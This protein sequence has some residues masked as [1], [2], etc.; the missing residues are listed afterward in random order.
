MRGYLKTL[1]WI[2]KLQPKSTTIGRHKDSDLCL[3]NSGVDE[4][5]ATID[6][7]EADGCY[8][9]RDLNSAHGTYVNDCRIHNATVRLSPG[10]QLHFGYGGSTYELCID[11][12]K[13]FP[14]LAAQSPIP[15]AWGRARTPSVSPHPPTRPRPLSAGSKQGPNAPDRKTQSS[16]PGSWS[17]NTGRAC[18][19]RSK[20]P[21]NNCQSI[22]V[23]PMEEEERLHRLGDGHVRV[24]LCFEDESQRK[25]DAIM[26]LKEEVSALKLQLSQKKQGDPDVP[27]RLRCLEID[28]KEK[29]DQIQQL[30]DQ[31]LELQRCSGEMLGQAVTERD[32]RISSLL[33]QMEKLRN[34]NN[35]S[36]ALV[37]SLKKDVSAREKQAVKLATEVDKLRQDVRHKDA[38]LTSMMDK[39]EDTQKHQNE[40]LARQREAESLRKER[41]SLLTE[42]DR[43]KQLHQQTQQK[44]QRVQAEL[45]HTQSRFD[46]FR[47]RIVKT[48]QVSEKESDQKVLDHLTGLMEQMAMYKTKVH[49]CEMKFKEEAHTQRKV[50]DETQKFRARLQECQRRVQDACIADTVLMEISGLQD[51]NLSPSFSWVQEHSLSILNLLHKVLQNAAQSLQ[52]AGVDVSLKTGGVSGALQIL[53]QEHMDVQSELRKLKS[54]MQK[55]RETE[56]QSRDLHSRLEFMQKQFETEKLQAAEGQ[57]EMKNTLMRQLEEVMADLQSTR[58]AESALRREIET[59][60]AEWQAKME[61]AKVREA[62]LK[63]SLRELHLKE[64]ERSEKMKQCEEREAKALQRRAEEERQKHRV[65]VEE[66]REQVRQHAYTIV[67]M[68]TRINNAKQNEERWNKMEE[69]RDSLKEQLR[70]ALCRLEGFESSSSSTSYTSEK[71]QEPDQT[72]T[73]LRESLALSQ[74]E[75]VSQSEIINALSH[76]LAQAHARFSDMTGELNEQQK[77]ELESHKALVVDQKI[78]LSMLTQKLTMMSQLVEQKDEEIKKLGEKLR[79]TEEDLK[80]KATANRAMENASLVPL[81]TS[82]NTKDVALMTAPND[83]INQGS[84]HK[85]HRREEVILQQHEGLRD[86]KERIRVLEQKWPSKRLS[87]Q[88]EPEKQGQMKTQRLQRSA[89]RT[90]SISSVSGFAFPEALTEAARERTAR[91]DMSDA[92]ELSERTYLELARVLREALELSDGELSGYASL[93]H[94]PPDERQRIVSMRQTDL[95]FVRTR[96]DLQNRQSQQQELLLQENQREIHTLRE[97]QG[98]GYQT[99]SELESVKAEL[100][101]QRQ[102]TEQLR[103]ALQDSINQLQR[104]QQERSVTNRNNRSLSTE[105]TDRKSGRVGHHNCIP[106]ESYEK[107][108][109]VKKRTSQMRLQRKESEVDNLKKEMGQKQQICSVVSDLASPLQGPESSLLL[110]LT[111]AH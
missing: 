22:H 80:R 81:Q 3:Q 101:T 62:E 8:A 35:S 12:K 24:S 4:C 103:Q 58:Q 84:K 73:S 66:Y 27:H 38:K 63:E 72:I 90:G 23:F 10:D 55:I 106:N 25:D 100:E 102:E 109:A 110:Q 37:N 11:S 30:K 15:Q 44:E 32:Q 57:R 13:S 45:K 64:E 56:I 77:L 99:Q 52:T 70:E 31:M 26:A 82:R 41:S 19:L 18:Y 78:Q 87:Q 91:L 75:V 28:I 83:V 97:S 53:C 47:D 46:S 33:E 111:E 9:V 74:Q 14:L 29:K 107:A 60:K 98:L 39:L 96:L 59:R 79:Q 40:L 88:G 5:H 61:E 34:E 20:T 94:L 108:P 48:V 42:I 104:N 51:M 68:E 43:L 16:R 36:A 93:K 6:W 1:N 50:L 2:F 89:A 76:D 65:E 7:C 67:A 17:G 71:Q 49:D 54:E 86:M 95:E 85:G 105:R 69:E 92:L 21:P